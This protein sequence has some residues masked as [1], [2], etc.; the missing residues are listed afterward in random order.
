MP[1]P[2]P[3]PISSPRQLLV[4]GKSAERFLLALLRH[5]KQTHI[6]VQDYGG[7]GDLSAFLKTLTTDPSF[8]AQVAWLGIA[9]DAEDDANT[10]LQ[11]VCRDLR[12]SG[13]PVPSAVM[14]PA[15]GP[16]Q[17]SVF[18][19]PDCAKKGM[20]EDLC[21]GA[22]ASDRAIPCVNQYFAC[23]QQQHI[24]EPNPL[25]KAQM[26]TFLASRA[27]PGLHLGEAADARYFDFDHSAFDLLK[28]FLYA[29]GTSP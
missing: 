26:Q 24:D 19:F 10:A 6:Q 8:T 9:R 2:R 23:L 11:N 15:A 29:L 20:L 22:V 3:Q 13:L 25:P 1:G 14:A 4:E 28:Q 17:V 7:V 27:K 18:L 12:R 5:I 16:P 21:L